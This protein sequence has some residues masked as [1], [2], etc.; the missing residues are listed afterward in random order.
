MSGVYLAIAIGAAGFLIWIILD[1]LKVYAGLKPKVDQ[2]NMEIQACQEQVEVEQVSTNEINQQVESV[3]KDIGALEKE[4][5]E[6][7]KKVEKFRQREK[8]RKPTKFK[9][10]E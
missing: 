10:E 4:I 5:V 6:L 9:L 3:Q 8:R 2:A 1:Y 7:S